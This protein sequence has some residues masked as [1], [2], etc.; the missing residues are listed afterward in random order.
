[1]NRDGQK[2]QDFIVK[3]EDRLNDVYHRDEVSFRVPIQFEEGVEYKINV[4]R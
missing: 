1:V 2:A 3:D 4:Y